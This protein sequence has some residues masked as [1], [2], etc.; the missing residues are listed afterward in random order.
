MKTTNPTR[1]NPT[2]GIRTE[3]REISIN[4]CKLLST[5]VEQNKSKKLTE[6]F[7]RKK[8]ICWTT[9]GSRH[10]GQW[11]TSAFDK[12]KTMHISLAVKK[13]NLF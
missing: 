6:E 1:T 10:L 9:S 7:D 2:S 5:F 4:Q 8:D 11:V 13:Q 3:F 12:F